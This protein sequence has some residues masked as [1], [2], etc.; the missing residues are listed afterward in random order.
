MM[1]RI[2]ILCLTAVLLLGAAAA[3]TTMTADSVQVHDVALDM[4]GSTLHY[5]QLTG[6]ADEA[7]Q[8]AANDAIMTAGQIEKRINR[9]AALLTSPV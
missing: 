7:V 6:I 5:P 2:F 1:K 3:E 9:M 8:K 4:L